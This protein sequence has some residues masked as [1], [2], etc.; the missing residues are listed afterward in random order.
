LE[1]IWGKNSIIIFGL[2]VMRIEGYIGSGGKVFEETSELE[3]SVNSIDFV[4]RVGRRRGQWP[5]LVK[6][7]SLAMHL[8]VLRKTKSSRL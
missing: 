8:Q 5:I 6:C 2:V 1:E 4:G 7:M 3:L